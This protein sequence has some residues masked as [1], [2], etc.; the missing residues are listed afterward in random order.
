MAVFQIT[1][2]MPGWSDDE[3]TA[4]S[5]RAQMC[6]GWFEGVRWLRSFQDE[7]REVFT[8]YYEA[9]DEATVRRHAELAEIPC[10]EVHEVRE[11]LLV[12]GVAS[13]AADVPAVEGARV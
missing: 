11:W 10:D 13:L 1:R 4:G 5:V 6:A 9:P 2:H 8:C 3:L 12:D 7:Q